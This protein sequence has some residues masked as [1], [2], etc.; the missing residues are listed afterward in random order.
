MK[1]HSPC[2][3]CSSSA[4]HIEVELQRMHRPDPRLLAA[5]AYQQNVQR[6]FKDLEHPRLLAVLTNNPH[7]LIQRITPTDTSSL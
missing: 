3:P 1:L 4:P 5:M 6:T 7:S 2:N